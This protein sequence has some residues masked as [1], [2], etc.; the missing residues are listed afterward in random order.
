MGICEGKEGRNER[1]NERTLGEGESLGFWCPH[2]RVD[3][4]NI[5]RYHSHFALSTTAINPQI[6]PTLPHS[7]ISPLF[8]HASPISL[9]PR[10]LLTSPHTTKL[11]QKSQKENAMVAPGFEPRISA[12]GVATPLEGQVVDQDGRRL[13]RP[14]YIVLP[15]GPRRGGGSPRLT[16]YRCVLPLHCATESVGGRGHIVI[17]MVT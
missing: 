17:Y 7:F 2:L 16:Q 8:L 9:H 14:L 6:L 10:I 12:S 1:T 11:T 5:H 15:H 3:G 13:V 4:G